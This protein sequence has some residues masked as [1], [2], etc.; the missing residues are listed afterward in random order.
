MCWDCCNTSQVLQIF[1]LP[2]PNT[3]NFRL[4][5]PRFGRKDGP[6]SLWRTDSTVSGFLMDHWF[7]Q[8]STSQS[9]GL[10]YKWNCWRFPWVVFYVFSQFR[11]DGCFLQ[12]EAS[13]SMW[14]WLGVSLESSDQ[15]AMQLG[16][17]LSLTESHVFLGR[18]TERLWLLG[19]C[20]PWPQLSRQERCSKWAWLGWTL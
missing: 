8:V 5:N 1:L 16:P 3:S 12:P 9:Y 15:L 11:R 18:L 17:P 19:V 6:T 2:L 20:V 10:F 14:S 13:R 7:C 4:S